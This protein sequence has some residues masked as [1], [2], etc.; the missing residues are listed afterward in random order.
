VLD[1]DGILPPNSYA[2]TSSF[3]AS[4]GRDARNE[5]DHVFIRN[6][7]MYR[8]HLAQFNYT[9]YDVRRRQDV[10]NPNTSRHN[11]MVL[12][13]PDSDSAGDCPFWYARILGIY[14]VNVVYTG[15]GMLDHRPRRLEFLWVRW[16]SPSAAMHRWDACRL[17][18]V[19]FPPMAAENAFEFLDPKFVLRACH[20]VPAFASGKRHADG[21]G[22]SRCAKD[23][24]DWCSYYVMRYVR[25]HT[26][27][28][29]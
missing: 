19:Q 3:S 22:L 15:P 27:S 10:V 9:T 14:H 26:D 29:L 21:V 12:A 1:S 2:G 23:S 20:I 11:V 5:C 4:A 13:Q 25:S 16:Y 8:H 24:E 7:T 17:D 28:K 18:C 6:N